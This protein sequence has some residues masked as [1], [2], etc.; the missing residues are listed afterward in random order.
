[1]EATLLRTFALVGALIATLAL[2]A[3]ADGGGAFVSSAAG[4]FTPGVTTRADALKTLGPPSS[5]YEAA[6]GEK[7]LSWARDGGL[8]NS[9]ETRQYAI[10]F[11]PDDKMIRA[12]PGS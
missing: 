4:H 9:G 11:G 5:I 3:C 6:N 1:M 12:T 7:T 8:F 10:V 2:T